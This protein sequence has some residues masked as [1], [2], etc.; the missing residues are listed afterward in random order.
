MW[1][2][3]DTII[4]G[5]SYFR[6]LIIDWLT[7]T[8]YPFLKWQWI[9]FP[10]TSIFLLP[11][12]STRLLPWLDHI[13]STASIYLTFFGRLMLSRICWCVR[14]A[15]IFSFLCFSSCCVLYSMSHVTLDWPFFDVYLA[16]FICDFFFL[17]YNKY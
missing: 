17:I 3:G 8:K 9:F 2:K 6:Y 4:T 16:L 5:T 13:C 12:P 1:G 11:V 15:H 7:V 10:L 14:N